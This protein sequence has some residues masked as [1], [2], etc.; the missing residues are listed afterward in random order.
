LDE[1][2]GSA[3]ALPVSFAEDSE[4]LEEAHIYLAPPKRHLLAEGQNLALGTGPRENWARPA[5]DP[6]MRSV[7][8]CCGTRAI[9]VILTGALGDG[10]SGLQAIRRCGGIAVVQDPSDAAF[11]EMP[12][13]ALNLAAPQHVVTL[14]EMSF[15]LESLVHQPTGVPM[16]C[17]ERL[18][19]EVKVAKGEGSSIEELERIGHRSVLSCPECGG[20][21]WEIEEGDGIRY[22]CHVGHALSAEAM[23]VGI[24]DKV[25]EALYVALRA[26]DEQAAL[27]D[28]LLAEAAAKGRNLSSDFWMRKKE[29]ADRQRNVLQSAIN[30]TDLQ[31]P[32][33]TGKGQTY[34]SR[35]AQRSTRAKTTPE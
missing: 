13:S 34:P 11:S 29:E 7:A 4:P 8:V 22:R 20:V 14:S 30:H 19:F 21:M 9:G 6:M 5:I 32:N 3:G 35:P 31:S 33:E 15:L 17:P 26:P 23:S 24:T 1:I 16:P 25:R 27:T 18:K 28:K 2:L 10:A 12:S